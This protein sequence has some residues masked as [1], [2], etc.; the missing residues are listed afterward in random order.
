MPLIAL[1]SSNG[2][3]IDEHFV[4]CGRFYIYDAVPGHAWTLVE[5]RTH[6]TSAWGGQHQES[7]L[8]Q[9]A[10]LVKDCSIVLVSRIGPGAQ[11][12]LKESG[13]TAM[14]QFISLAH[15]QDKL[16]LG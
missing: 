1:G 15:A 14:T 7:L 10:E 4:S 2:E 8:L 5:I 16:A 6:D 12:L 3:W 11:Q 13:I 9:A